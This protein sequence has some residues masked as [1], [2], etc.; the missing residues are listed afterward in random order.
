VYHSIGDYS[1]IEYHL[2]RSGVER[3]GIA[4][5]YLSLDSM[6]G[7]CGCS[8]ITPTGISAI[9]RSGGAKRLPIWFQP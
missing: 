4:Y 8:G 7:T 9:C 2:A 5:I 3:I 1:G 6:R